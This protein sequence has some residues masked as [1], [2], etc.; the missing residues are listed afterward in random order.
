MLCIKES[1]RFQHFLHRNP[2]SS[3]LG[4]LC[5][6]LVASSEPLLGHIASGL[7]HLKRNKGL[8][9]PQTPFYPLLTRTTPFLSRL[10]SH[11]K[12][13]QN[14]VLTPFDALHQKEADS[15]SP[16]LRTGTFD[17]LI[18]GL[19]LLGPFCLFKLLKETLMLPADSPHFLR[20][21]L[22]LNR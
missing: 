22:I 2:A 10:I 4:G 11:K 1:L 9:G 5:G 17:I 19:E 3:L 15:S 20:R 16:P 13:L 12:T 7:M 8:G 14:Q 21:P 18:L 6:G